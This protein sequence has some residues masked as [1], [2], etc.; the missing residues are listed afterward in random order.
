MREDVKYIE[1]S[2]INLACAQQRIENGPTYMLLGQNT[3]PNF[4]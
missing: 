4:F 3:T 1:T 2:L